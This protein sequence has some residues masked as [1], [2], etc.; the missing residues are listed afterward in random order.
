MSSDVAY[1]NVVML[2]MD[3]S[4]DIAH[5]IV[6]TSYMDMPSDEVHVIVTIYIDTSSDVDMLLW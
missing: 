5:A 4:S 2:Y 6:L 3:T 1:A